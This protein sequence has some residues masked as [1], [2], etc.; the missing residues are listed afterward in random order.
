MLIDGF[1][2]HFHLTA[3]GTEPTHGIHCWQAA[4]AAKQTAES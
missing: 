2:Q 1:R 3:H 4:P